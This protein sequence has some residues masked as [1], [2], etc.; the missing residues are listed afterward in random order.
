MSRTELERQPVPVVRLIVPDAAGRVLLLRRRPGSEAGGEWCLP[1]GKVG[2]GET[3]IEA[4]TKEL[5]EETALA[6]E[7]LRFLFYQD[8]L[9][10]RPGGMHCIELYFECRVSGEIALDSESTEWARVGPE[11]LGRYTIAFRNLDA[12]RRYWSAAP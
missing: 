3:V 10:M 11:D 5:R 6:S 9:A 7:D 12:L 8:S 4:A 1:G 2:H